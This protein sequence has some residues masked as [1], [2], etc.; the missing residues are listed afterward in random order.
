M[1]Q[2]K[3]Y[4]R[5]SKKFVDVAF[6]GFVECDFQISAAASLDSTRLNDLQ[7]LVSG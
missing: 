1:D 6:N 5:S 3:N 7:G 4:E 2:Y